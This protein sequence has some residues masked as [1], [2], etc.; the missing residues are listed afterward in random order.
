MKPSNVNCGNCKFGELGERDPNDVRAPAPIHCHRYPPHV[1]P[2]QAG[3]QGIG[4]LTLFA[5]VDPGT[6]CGEHQPKLTN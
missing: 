5:A 1:F 6:W 2:L 3:R 4:S